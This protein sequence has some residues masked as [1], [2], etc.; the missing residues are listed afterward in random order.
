M[1]CKRMLQLRVH[2]LNPAELINALS[3]QIPIY[4]EEED[5]MA[6]WW[7]RT[8][9]VRRRLKAIEIAQTEIEEAK[10]TRGKK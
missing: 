5:A 4:R 6:L 8:P 1:T 10:E 9:M 2:P 3:T 7:T